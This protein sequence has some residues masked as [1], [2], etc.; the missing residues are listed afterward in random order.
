M[1]V[2]PPPQ[3]MEPSELRRLTTEVM[4]AAQFPD[5]ATIDNDCPR[6]RPVSP[7]RTE[8][9]TIYIAS[10]QSSHKTGELERNQ[11]VELCYM[12]PG[13]DHVRITG[14]MALVADADT[15]Q[16]IWDAN[17]LLRAYLK[18]IDNPEFL[19]Y[20]IHPVRVRYMKEWALQYHEVPL[21]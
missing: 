13:H 18:S 20:V 11:N 6:V 3:I 19:L 7:L 5:L 9:F 8:G 15:R 10:M 2:P 21:D 4:A 16:S 14:R 12:S 17:P 1:E